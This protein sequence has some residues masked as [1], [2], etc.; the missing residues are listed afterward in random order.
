[1]QATEKS[2]GLFPWHDDTHTL[3][4]FFLLSWIFNPDPQFG[5]HASVKK[6]DI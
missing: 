1:M 2:L 5:D 4:Q 6:K 3:S